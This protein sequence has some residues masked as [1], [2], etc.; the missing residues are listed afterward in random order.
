MTVSTLAALAPPVNVRSLPLIAT[1]LAAETDRTKS[2]SRSSLSWFIW[3][4][5]PTTASGTVSDSPEASARPRVTVNEPVSLVLASVA[6][7]SCEARATVVE[8]SSLTVTEVLPW[9]EDA[10]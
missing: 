1:P 4:F 3:L 5:R 10:V 9:L 6:V 7:V 2:L 8:S